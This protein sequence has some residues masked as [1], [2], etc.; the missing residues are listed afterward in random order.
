MKSIRRQYTEKQKKRVVLY[1]R[2]HGVRPS[3]RK[4]SIPRRNIQR[5]LNSFCDSDFDRASRNEPH[6]THNSFHT[7]PEHAIDKSNNV[8]YIVTN[9]PAFCLNIPQKHRSSRY[10]AIAPQIPT[11]WVKVT[12]STRHTQPS[13]D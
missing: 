11:F 9:H 8:T 12:R 5:W 7:C 2:H 1:A 6:T 13:S 4:F 3:E 10:P